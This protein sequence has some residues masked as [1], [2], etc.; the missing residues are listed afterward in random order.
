MKARRQSRTAQ[1]KGER[2]KEGRGESRKERRDEDKDTATKERVG[3]RREEAQGRNNSV[4]ET[5]HGMN[6]LHNTENTELRE[7]RSHKYRVGENP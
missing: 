1:G 3:Y 2:R 7:G 5:E 4:G 6:P